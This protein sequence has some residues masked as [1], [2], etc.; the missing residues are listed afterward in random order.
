MVGE[1]R[2]VS[3]GG[4]VAAGREAVAQEE[5]WL[6]ALLL[7]GAAHKSSAEECAK[8]ESCW[9]RILR[10]LRLRVAGGGGAPPRHPPLVPICQ[11]RNV[12]RKFAT[13]WEQDR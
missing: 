1:Q 3:E 2:A 8:A 6:P 13:F 11:Q 10:T 4:A 12:G 7:S 5:V 9:P